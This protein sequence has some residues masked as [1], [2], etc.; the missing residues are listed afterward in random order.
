MVYSFNC[1]DLSL[2]LLS[3]FPKYFEGIVNGIVFLY[4]FSAVHY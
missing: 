2:P 1:G 4:S 3:L